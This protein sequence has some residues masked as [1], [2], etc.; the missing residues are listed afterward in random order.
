MRSTEER[1]SAVMQR[2]QELK[3]KRTVRSNRLIALSSIAASLALIVG[4][5][6]AMPGIMAQ[7]DSTVH[8]SVSGMGSIFSTNHAMGYVVVAFLAFTLGICVTILCVHLK[9]NTMEPRRPVGK[10]DD[11]NG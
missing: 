9:R 6:L 3:H 10:G 7:M 1:M 8:L 2:T 5:A 11:P 4:T